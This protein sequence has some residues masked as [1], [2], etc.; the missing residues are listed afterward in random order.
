MR[1]VRER[2]FRPKRTTAEFDHDHDAGG[3]ASARDLEAKPLTQRRID[4]SISGIGSAMGR[5]ERMRWRRFAR[6]AAVIALGVSLSSCGSDSSRIG[7]PNI[8]FIL[9]DSLRADHLPSYGYASD[10]APA[11]RRLAQ[12]GVLF[13]RVIAPSSWTKTSM[14]SIMTA[15][16]PSRHGVLRHRDLLPRELST[17]AEALAMH[18]YETIGV[19]T[20]PWL[21]PQ[22]GFAAGFRVYETLRKVKKSAQSAEV[23]ERALALLREPSRRVPVFLYLHYMDVHGPYQPDPAFV[24]GKPVTLPG[25]EVIADSALEEQYRKAGLAAPGVQARVIEL[26]DGGIRTLDAA[27]EELLE[28]MR[29]LIDFNHTIFVVTSDHGE[30]FREH[31]TTEHGWNLYPEV[32]E[33]PL[34][35]VWPERLSK[36]IRIGA[37]VRSIDIAP[38]ILALAGISIPDSFEG[39]PLLPMK[40]GE[41]D[42][43]IANSEVRF[44]RPRPPYHYT[45]VISPDH[46]YQREK[47]DDVEEFY[48]LRVDPG[49]THD[50]GGAHPRAIKLAEL[51]VST[52]IPAPEQRDLDAETRDELKALGYLQ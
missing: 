19:N 40:P 23:N 25:G 3:V 35:F 36:A 4:P 15:R 13:E 9:I 28:G 11:L 5:S 27:V 2:I 12:K 1:K 20:N 43:R 16:N 45:A 26:Y 33:V 17:L 24:G 8:V 44:R 10:T 48:D 30:S 31:G 22:F 34:I 38:T 29:P 41:V 39:S 18:G 6:V 14:A 32:I 21:K 7:P 47:F 42:A 46:F 37:Q 52:P 49:A 51:E 50:L